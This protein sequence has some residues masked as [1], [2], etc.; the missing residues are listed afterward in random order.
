MPMPERP[1]LSPRD[2][3]G[4]ITNAIFSWTDTEFAAVRAEIED[5]RA[6]A[7]AGGGGAALTPDPANDGFYVIPSGSTLTPDP[8]NSGF[9]K[10]GA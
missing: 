9:Y 5:V 8:D 2:V 7:E 1:A 10:I 4:A 6:I 3:W